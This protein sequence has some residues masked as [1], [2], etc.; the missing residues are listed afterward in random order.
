[1]TQKAPTKKARTPRWQRGFLAALKDTGNVRLACEA[2]GVNRKTA[3][4]RR[5][6][7]QSFANLWEEAIDEAADLL[8]AEAVR[9]ARVGVEEP[10]VYQGEI[11]GMWI[12]PKSGKTVTQDTP[13]A[14]LVPTTVTR[15]SDTLLI[16]LLKGARPEKYRER[17]EVRN[18]E[19]GSEVDQE[20]A[21]LTKEMNERAAAEAP[22]RTT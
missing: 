19:A 14:V 22:T 2:V 16:F 1:M 6:S 21:A 9:R 13:G 11:Q 17:F 10:V 20:I 12:D 3:Y 15:Y 7:D 18:I 4:R 8:E 5:A